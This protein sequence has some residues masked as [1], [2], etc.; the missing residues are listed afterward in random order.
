MEGAIWLI[1]PSLTRMEVRDSGGALKRRQF[2]IKRVRVI[3]MSK[4]K[5]LG[6][7]FSVLSGPW[8]QV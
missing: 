7:V 8:K 4:R 6:F 5:S 2:V 3:V 1:R